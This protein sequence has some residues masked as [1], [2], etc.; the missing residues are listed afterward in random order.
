MILS[1]RVHE[2]VVARASYTYTTNIHRAKTLTHAYSAHIYMYTVAQRSAIGIH[3]HILSPS[4]S[5][6]REDGGCACAL[7]NSLRSART[8]AVIARL[9]QG[10]NRGTPKPNNANKWRG[11]GKQGKEP[12]AGESSIVRPDTQTPGMTVWHVI[13]SIRKRMKGH[14]DTDDAPR[15]NTGNQEE[16]AC[17]KDGHLKELKKQH[18]TRGQSNRRE[19]TD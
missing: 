5:S 6:G 12:D 16:H 7:Y 18:E 14:R 11:R 4:P 8:V 3:T 19:S 10:R 9:L 15:N 2:S 1:P 13:K 17:L